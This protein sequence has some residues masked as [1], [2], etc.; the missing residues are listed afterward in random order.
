MSGDEA[1][2]LPGVYLAGDTSRGASLIV[3]A[4]SDG[5]EA[6]R[7]IDRALIDESGLLFRGEGSSL[8][9]DASY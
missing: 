9:V 1:E 7:E 6:V 4:S 2:N 5:R 8:T 3:W